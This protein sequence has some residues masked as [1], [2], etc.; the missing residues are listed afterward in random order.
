MEG[1]GMAALD[2]E[3]A[4]FYLLMGV[5]EQEVKVKYPPCL[6]LSQTPV[7]GLASL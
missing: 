4:H 3:H 6:L 1:S 7:A 5:L 2:P